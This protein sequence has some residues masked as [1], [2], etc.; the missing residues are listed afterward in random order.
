MYDKL[1]ST[2]SKG[3]LVQ[4]TDA[5]LEMMVKAGE[6]QVKRIN[7]KRIVPHNVNR[8]STL[9]SARKFYGK[10][11]KILGAGFSLTK[12]DEKRAVCFG[13]NPMD[14]SAVKRFVDHANASPNFASFDGQSIEACSV[15]CGHLNQF[16]AAI[17]DETEVPEDLRND[18][19]IV[20]TSEK[21]IDKHV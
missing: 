2:E 16:L 10:G 9:M 18:E 15:G 4:L 3:K 11:A 21:H 14:T 13:S 7:C 1:V 19:D 20:M 5:M 6:A 12:C 17:H 8:M